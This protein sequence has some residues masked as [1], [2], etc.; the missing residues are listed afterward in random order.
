MTVATA[1]VHSVHVMQADPVVGNAVQLAEVLFTIPTSMTYAQA[2]NAILTGVATLIQNSRRN[3]KTVTLLGVVGFQRASKSG[4]TA[5]YLGVKTAAISSADVTFEVTLN[6]PTT[7]Y[8]NATAMV[9]QSRP[10]SVLV[11]FTEADA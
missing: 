2:D 1:T 5:T 6:S 7:E 9:E 11:T 8:T 10:F 4:D 3:G